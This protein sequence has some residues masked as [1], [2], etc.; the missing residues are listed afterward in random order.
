M[1]VGEPFF[2]DLVVERYD[3]RTVRRVLHELIREQ[4]IE[5][6]RIQGFRRWGSAQV[7]GNDRYQFSLEQSK[8]L[9]KELPGVDVLRP[10]GSLVYRIGRAIIYPRRYGHH[11]DDCPTTMTLTGSD[12]QLR[13]SKGIFPDQAD[14]F[15]DT[16]GRP[17]VVVLGFTGNHLDGGPQVA[18]LG[19]PDGI[20]K[21]GQVNW[22]ALEPLLDG[23]DGD[24][25]GPASP[26]NKPDIDSPGGIMPAEVD[27]STQP[28]PPLKL[29]LR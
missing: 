7:H 13:M 26:A 11:A 4:Y 1:R 28:E 8:A 15:N 22:K 3:P 9:Q 5:A 12:I 23:A 29:K 25:A 24:E 21:N 19:L 14:L 6:N 2:D 18:Y 10:S 17:E 27:R 20:T 16:S